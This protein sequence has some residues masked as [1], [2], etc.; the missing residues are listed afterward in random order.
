MALSCSACLVLLLALLFSSTH[1]SEVEAAINP[2]LPI[3]KSIGGGSRY[4]R[5]DF[6]MR[7]LGSD[8][9]SSNAQGQAD[10]SIIAVDLLTGNVT[11]TAA[12]IEPGCAA[13]VKKGK[14]GE[15]KSSLEQSASAVK[16]C[17]DGFGRSHVASPL[18]VEDDN[19]FQ[20]AKL[21][22]ALLPYAG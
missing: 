14:Y 10:L 15:A 20:L 5:I 8:S 11:S 13:A 6:C 22:V 17:E 3:C 16:E 2:L 4:V 18:T 21:G 1:N 19:A 9:R 12:M 7:A